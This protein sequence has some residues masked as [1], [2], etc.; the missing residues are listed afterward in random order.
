M[1]K[2]TSRFLLNS[3]LL[4]VLVNGV[5]NGVSNIKFSKIHLFLFNSFSSYYQYFINFISR[6][7]LHIQNFHIKNKSIP[8][9]TKH[10]CDV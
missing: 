9:S 3:A 2:Y 5:L 8:L 1:T 6:K 10:L 4:R 7:K